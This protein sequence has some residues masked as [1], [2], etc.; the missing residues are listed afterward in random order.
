MATT[1]PLPDSVLA[2]R[3]QDG[4]PDAF[5]F[6]VRRHQDTVYR[7]ALRVLGDEADAADTAQEALIAAWHRLPDLADVERFGSWL[8][9]IASRRALNLARDRAPEAPTDSVDEAGPSPTPEQ[10]SLAGGLRD[11][12]AEALT[13]LPPP[14]R[15]CWVLRELEGMGYAEI[16]E[17]VDTTPNA[18]RGRIHR[19]RTQL[20]EV[21]KPW[22]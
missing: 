6:L 4:D 9:R 7:I 19:A 12:L 13:G 11:A 3:A 15:I 10:Y 1:P 18:V 2:A 22:R 5:E 21:L 14:Q 17:I 16:A 8:Y 20:V